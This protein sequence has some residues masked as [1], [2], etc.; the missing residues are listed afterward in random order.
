MRFVKPIITLI[1]L[2]LVAAFI[3]QNM[4]TFN[5]L[6]AF[7]LSLYFGQPMVWS[8]S[9]ASLIITSLVVGLVV[10]ILLMLKPY[11]GLR[12]KVAQ[13]RQGTASQ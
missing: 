2:G 4:P 12:K 7:K 5:T 10:G 11:L 8:F 6:Q 13:E 9:V 3:W 1:I